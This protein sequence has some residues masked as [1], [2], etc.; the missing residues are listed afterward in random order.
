MLKVALKSGYSLVLPDSV[1]IKVIG[2]S[3]PKDPTMHVSIDILDVIGIVAIKP[4]EAE[5][6]SKK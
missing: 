6:P 3:N 4:D 1:E 2:D 5:L